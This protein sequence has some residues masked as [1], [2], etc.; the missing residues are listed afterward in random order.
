MK[1]EEVVPEETP[2]PKSKKSLVI[3][4]IVVAIIA[5]LLVGWKYLA[6][7]QSDSATLTVGSGQSQINGSEAKT[8]RTLK[9]GDSVKTLPSS[10]ATVSFPEGTEIRLDEN[11]EIKINSQ[12]QNISIFQSVGKTWSR[13][14]N[15]LGV[16]DYEVKS[17][18]LTAS[19]RGTAFSNEVTGDKTNLDVD[20]G[21]VSAAGEKDKATIEAGKGVDSELGQRLTKRAIRKEVLE[22]T[23]FKKNRDR[24]QILLE[25]IRKRAGS[26]LQ[27]I[28]NAREV[29]PSD[30]AK[31][32]GLAARF[33]SGGAM[34]TEA[35]AD[36]IESLDLQ[37]P[38]GIARALAII[39]PQNFSDTRHW[40]RVISTIFP[41]IERFGVE[42]VLQQ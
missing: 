29:S 33:G 38:S 19:V 40:S 37:S 17:S 39:D 7:A 28:K 18:G 27:L 16:V 6:Q 12:G 22:S 36:Q 11:T 26:P 41:L 9:D 21:L 30:I 3:L 4:G 35:Q 34:I 8:G 31:L 13:V 10:N 1:E 42:K 32:R 23:W 25:K 15:L 24:D 14:I 5:L 2:K 20:E